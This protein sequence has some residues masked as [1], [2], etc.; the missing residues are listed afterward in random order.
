MK[1][2]PVKLVATIIGI[3]FSLTAFAQQTVK[4]KSPE[5]S[6]PVLQTTTEKA[7]VAPATE[8]KL[9]E[10]ATK[11]SSFNGP[12]P[13]KINDK[14][15]PAKAPEQKSLPETDKLVPPNRVKE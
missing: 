11:Q 6:G 7:P 14:A 4:A 15:E 12:A 3:F 10:T 8:T 5:V 2:T 9:K 1:N 13:V